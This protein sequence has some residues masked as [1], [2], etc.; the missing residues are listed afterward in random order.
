MPPCPRTDNGS[1]PAAVFFDGRGEDLRAVYLTHKNLQAVITGLRQVYYFH[2]GTCMYAHLDLFHS[3]GFVLQFLLPLVCDM[4]LYVAAEGD[5]NSALA[6]SE[7]YL[8]LCTPTQVRQLAETDV[9]KSFPILR[10]IFT[11]DIQT[12]DPAI[13]TLRAAGIQ[14]HT[15]AGM[16][17]TSSVC[18][19]NTD[20]FTGVDIAGKPLMQPGH[21][22]DSIGKP[23]PGVCLRAFH[24]DGITM[25]DAGE[26]GQLYI[27][28]AA[29]PEVHDDHWVD[30][31]WK[32]MVK[33]NG[34][35]VLR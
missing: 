16:N 28:G 23:L 6:K 2:Q 18:C 12:N 24:D 29:I 33:D 5:F 25:C 26:V 10:T 14:V 21:E 8:V 30:T 31:G 34:F 13:E 9:R 15:C 11:A 19:I 3:Y 27:K 17:R 4:S 32:G 7:A 35:V 1:L 22:S 20:H